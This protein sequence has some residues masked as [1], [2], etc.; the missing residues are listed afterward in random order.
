MNTIKTTTGN[1]TIYS[2]LIESDKLIFICST[3]IKIIDKFG[4]TVF[5]A[6]VR[7]NIDKNFEDLNNPYIGN[8]LNG[9]T[10]DIL[11]EFNLK[12]SSIRKLISNNDIER[13]VRYL[14]V[15]YFQDK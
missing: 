14:S 9:K 8:K 6:M 12:I 13:F 15:N 2:Y 10:I 7:L 4:E 11:K 3:Y 5:D 1:N